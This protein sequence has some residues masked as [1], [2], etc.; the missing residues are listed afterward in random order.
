MDW[1]D[2]T[3]NKRQYSREVV[4]IEARYQ[5]TAGNV[6]RGTV[7]NIGAGGVYIQTQHPLHIGAPLSLG[8]DFIEL[9][10][11]IDVHGWVV[12]VDP[13]KAMAVEFTRKDDRALDS[14]LSML[15]R[16]DRQRA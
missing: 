5:D 12:R 11:V 7:L 3:D 13:G 4:K 9:G 8:L 2:S 10:K 15:K 1:L 16:V 14:L 6:L